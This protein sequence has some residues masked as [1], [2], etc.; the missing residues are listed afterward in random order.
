CRFGGAFD[1]AVVDRRGVLCGVVGVI[2]VA[3]NFASTSNA[4]RP[5][6]PGTG[7]CLFHRC[8]WHRRFSRAPFAFWSLSAGR[9]AGNFCCYLVVYFWVPFALAGLYDPRRQTD[10]VAYQRH[11]VYLGRGESIC[12]TRAREC[13]TLFAWR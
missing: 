5:A 7:F 3:G 1:R 11:L 12:S 8:G 10:S 6:R 4:A 2:C 13:T 9:S